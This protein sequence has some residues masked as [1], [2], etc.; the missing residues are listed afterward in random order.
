MKWGG[1]LLLF[2]AIAENRPVRLR[3]KAAS[4][5]E[6]RELNFAAFCRYHCSKSANAA[7]AKGG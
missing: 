4:T 2:A 1:A 6:L 7:A 3:Q 5:I